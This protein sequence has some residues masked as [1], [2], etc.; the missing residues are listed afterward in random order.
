MTD[1]TGKQTESNDG[2]ARTGKHGKPAVGSG[3]AK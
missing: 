3:R 1:K 2:Y